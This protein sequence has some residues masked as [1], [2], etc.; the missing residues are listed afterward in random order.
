MILPAAPPALVQAA[1]QDS[2]LV[3]GQKALHAGRPLEARRFLEAWLAAHPDD[4]DARVAA[5]FAD[6]RLDRVR[7]AEAQFRRA[8]ERAPGYADAAYGLGLCLLREGRD[9]EGRTVLEAAL[10]KEPARAELKEAVARARILA[11]DPP[12]PMAPLARPRSLQMPA[13]IEGQRFEVA[14]G[15]GGWRAFFIKG[16]NLGAALPG[17]HPSE[18]PDKATYAGWI[19]EMAELGVNAIRVYTIHPPGF[20]EALA[21][22]NAKAAKPIWLIHGVWTELPPGDDFRE[23]GWWSRWRLEMR[24][25]VDL[26]HG[27]ADIPPSPGHASG[28]YRADVSKWTLAIILGREWEPFSVEAYNARHPGLSDY[29]GRFLAVTQGNATEVFM[30]VAMDY[31]L[32]YEFD[33]YHAQRPLAYTNWPTLD[34]LTHPTESTKDEELAWRRKLGLPLGKG[35]IHEY[36]NDAVGLD[37]EKVETLP[38][39]RAG[40]F[41]SYH[42]YP[43]YP[44]FMNLDPGYAK[45]GDTYAAYLRDLVAHHRRHPVVISEFGVPSSRLVAHWQP[46]GMTH[47]GQSEREQGEQDARLFRD[48]HDSGCAGGMLFAWIDEWF[49]KNWLVIDDEVPLERKPLWYNV[50]DAEENYG[51]LAYH[52]GAA[53]P[54]IRIDGRAGDWA[55]VPD[56]LAGPD[57]RLKVLADEGW[58]HLGLFFRGP[59]PDWAKEG[60]AVGIDTHGVDL[61]DHRLPW[62]LDLRSQ[63]GLEF[64]VRFQGDQTA[65][66]A[67]APY[68]LFT[69]RLDRPIRSV[70]NDAGRFVMP[71][72][73]SNRPR[74]GRDGTRFPGHRQEIGWLRRGTQDRSDPAFDSRAEWREGTAGDGWSFLEARIPWGLLNVTDPSS[75]RVIRDAIPPGDEVGTAVTEGFRLCLVR[76][77]TDGA[78][79]LQPAGSLPAAREGVLPL[80]PLFTWATWEQPTFHRVRKQSFDLV[81]ACLHGL[82]D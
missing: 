55:K 19:T 72:T 43:Y 45:G 61:G 76:F 17:R 74:I 28:A 56:Y 51:L 21:E 77:R 38:G 48:I 4:A 57:L 29:R 78:G 47:G 25:V 68:D 30:T 1:S 44:D 80:P 79:R 66:Y 26:I 53:G 81:K 39:C 22:H 37:L 24:R 31:F 15:K 40:I 64:V 7:E 14:D 73:E 50:E 54:S 6:L 27:R 59:I 75:R 52:P 23:E 3:Q 35:E 58:L 32:D 70:D 9:R 65:L 67:D 5:G 63:A 2:L 41:A 82:P 13:R 8:L 46:Q 62:G 16:I 36:D 42:A 49:K 34:P 20:Y 11:P 10:A 12:P 71:M 33:T 69:H 60:L 18:F